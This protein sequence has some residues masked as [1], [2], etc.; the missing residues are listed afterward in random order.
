L[1]ISSC[2]PL[3]NVIANVSVSSNYTAYVLYLIENSTFIDKTVEYHLQVSNGMAS[4]YGFNLSNKTFRIQTAQQ[5]ITV[6]QT[7]VS[8]VNRI[9]PGLTFFKLSQTLNKKFIVEPDSINIYTTALRIFNEQITIYNL[10]KEQKEFTIDYTEGFILLKE[11]RFTIPANSSKTV[12]VDIDASA[13]LPGTNTG[14]IYVRS[15]DAEERVIINL[16]ITLEKK[17]EEK[18]P[19]K[20]QPKPIIQIQKEQPTELLIVLA[21]LFGLITLFG[22]VL[23]INLR[24][25]FNKRKNT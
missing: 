1:I 25:A 24:R 6:N 11:T 2:C 7:S 5:G 9:G 10:L 14:F 8:Y 17:A 23:F 21:I 15:R 3:N 13:A 22:I 12:L 16:D 18:L 20:E 19:E 4:F